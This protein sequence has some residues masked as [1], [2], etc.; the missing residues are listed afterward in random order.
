MLVFTKEE[1][2]TIE[3]CN[4]YMQTRNLGSTML[5]SKKAKFKPNVVEQDREE[6]YKTVITRRQRLT[7]Q[8]G[9]GDAS[10][11]ED[12]SNGHAILRSHKWNG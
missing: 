7:S 12:R 6:H 1:S 9:M 11:D 10:Q 4:Q 3:E 2:S 8:P 5:A